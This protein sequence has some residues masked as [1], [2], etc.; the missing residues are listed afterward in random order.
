MPRMLDII[1]GEHVSGLTVDG[2]GYYVN[3][4]GYYVSKH[5][6][7][8]EVLSASAEDVRIVAGGVLYVS[9]GGTATNVNVEE[10]GSLYMQVA[11]DTV[12]QGSYNGVAFNNSNGYVYGYT[13]NPLSALARVAVMSGGTA[14]D[15]VCSAGWVNANVG[16]L[17][18]SSYITSTGGLT[19]SG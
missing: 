2:N 5:G 11:P 6:S 17:L 15:I 9:S 14:T 7:A 13:H 10:D 3:D 1:N 16:G 18:T 19:L 12:V 8:P 4:V